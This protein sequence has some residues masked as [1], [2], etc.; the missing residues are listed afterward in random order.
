MVNVKHALGSLSAKPALMIA[1]ALLVAG[2]GYHYGTRYSHCT[3]HAE[4][5]ERLVN[6]IETASSSDQATFDLAGAV[7]AGW[8]QLKII[9]GYQ[10]GPERIDCPFGWDWSAEQRTAL[11]GDGGLTLLLFSRGGQFA[12]YIEV[13]AETVSFGGIEEPLTPQSATFALSGD[14]AKPPYQLTRDP[15]SG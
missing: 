5:R 14:P 8:D 2:L 12:D 10:P 9:K 13:K 11:A 6:A 3:K 15:A 1:P 7:P 4:M